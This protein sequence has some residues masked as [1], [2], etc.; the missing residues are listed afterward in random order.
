MSG[1]H[2]ISRIKSLSQVPSKV[3]LKDLKIADV[4]FEKE[5]QPC[6][7]ELKNYLNALTQAPKHTGAPR[8]LVELL[9]DCMEK[10]VSILPISLPRCS[11]SLLTTHYPSHR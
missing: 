10:Y 4:G 2:R 3:S 7:Q 9:S 6:A 5:P 8:H 1:P 11:L